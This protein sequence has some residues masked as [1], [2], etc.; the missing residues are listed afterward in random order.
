MKTKR[1]QAV[2]VETESQD[3][4]GSLPRVDKKANLLEKII[5]NTLI[6]QNPRQ[7]MH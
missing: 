5:I 3:K 7:E 4:V 1:K 2:K 6:D